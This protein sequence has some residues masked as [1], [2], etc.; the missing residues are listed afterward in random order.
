MTLP[1]PDPSREPITPG[2]QGTAAEWREIAEILASVVTDQER[3]LQKSI[4]IN[5]ALVNRAPRHEI[6]FRIRMNGLLSA[7]R[8]QIDRM[9]EIDITLARS[10][11]A[12]MEE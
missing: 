8:A 10:V 7:Q 11:V 2:F 1:Q 12:W 3:H 5:E 4:G 9:R 6:D